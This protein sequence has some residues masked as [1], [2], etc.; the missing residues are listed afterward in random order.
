MKATAEIVDLS[1]VRNSKPTGS[2]GG[3]DHF[4]TMVEGTVFCS[5]PNGSS[6]SILDE[7]LLC[8]KQGLTVLLK[9]AT[10]NG[11]ERHIGNKFWKQNTLVQIMHIPQQE[12]EQN[13]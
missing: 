9:N 3:D 6:S 11:F 10:T 13:G 8:A 2:G 5:V 1:E 4:V 12:E 7:Y